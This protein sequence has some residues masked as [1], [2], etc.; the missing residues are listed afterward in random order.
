MVPSKLAELWENPCFVF[1]A[2]SGVK[3]HLF[4]PPWEESHTPHPHC[5]LH[6]TP[7]PHL[8]LVFLETAV[9]L[10]GQAVLELLISLPLP[11]EYW[12]HLQVS[13]TGLSPG[14]QFFVDGL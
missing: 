5:V 4:T 9:T 3:R 13:A 14:L 1:G 12:D 8:L 10:I 6:S 11:L 2:V 7:H